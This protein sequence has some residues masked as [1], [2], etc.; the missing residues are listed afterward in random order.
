MNKYVEKVINYVKTK[1]QNE[2]EFIQ[3]VEEVLS[4][5]SPVI[6]EHS[7]Y[8]KVA[9]L[10]RIVEPERIVEFRVPWEDD[11]GNI[12]VNRGY[13]IQ[14]NG[15]IGPFK[16]GLRFASNVNLSILKFWDLSKHLKIL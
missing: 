16:G 9:L 4:S 12:H 10:E 8:E 2:P 5:L 3:T 13:R 7:E 11:A 1:N 14:F 15:A 6:D